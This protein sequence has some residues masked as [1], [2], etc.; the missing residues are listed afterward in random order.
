MVSFLKHLRIEN[1]TGVLRDARTPPMTPK[2][3]KTPKTPMTPRP[4]LSAMSPPC[5]PCSPFVLNATSFCFRKGP[6]RSV[7]YQPNGHP[8][9]VVIDGEI[10]PPIFKPKNVRTA[11]T[12]TFHDNDVVIATYPKCGTTWLQH[13]TSQLVKGHDYKAGKGNELCVQSP[14][15]ERMGAAFANEIKGPRVLKTHFHHYNIPKFTQTKYIYC[16]RNPKDCLTS[17]FH[18]NRNF[19][20]YNWANGT[21]DVF[22]DL[23]ASGQ[24]AFGDYFEHLLS[25]LP[26]LRDENV[27]F[28]KYEDMFQDLESAVFKIGQFL[29]GE[30][31]KRVED[32]EI[33]KE[34]VENSTIDAMKKDQKRWFPESQLHKV[35]FIRKGGSR[36]WKN[37]FTREQSDRI[38]SIFAAKFAGTPAEHW[39]K[40]EMAWDE[41]LPS[42]ENLSVAG[43][44][45]EMEQEEDTQSIKL[46]A[47]PPLPQRR[48]SR[49]S[50]L[51][52]GYGS[53]WS[54]SSQNAN[55]SASSSINNNLA[56]LGNFPE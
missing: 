26:G 24:L 25:W 8:K 33:L 7:V 46:F 37:H 29:G 23:F 22:V 15:I 38:D 4:N 52:T 35:E 5:T 3:P 55:M 28:L 53:V 16:V 40:Y 17:Y 6:A 1:E 49:T 36:D 41:K 48:F 12:M 30:A 31:A 11:K 2:L 20:I 51:S 13:I 42:I 50:L 54:L 21:W 10:W 45:E 32:P 56:N 14:M 18:H 9:Q 44:G 43:N 47:L 27:L 39:W 19:K 34:I